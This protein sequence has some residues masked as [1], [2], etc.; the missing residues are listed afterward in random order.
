MEAKTMAKS[1][2]KTTIDH[3]EIQHWVE[4]HN[5]HPARVRKTG[6]DKD[7][8]LL[9]IDFPGGTGSETLQEIPWEDWFKKFDQ[10]NLA[11]LYQDRKASGEDST[12]FKL[13]KREKRK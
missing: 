11:F 7:P 12:F 5:G 10:N 13:T 4:K 9:R 6:D 8:G 1:V 2:S 3:T